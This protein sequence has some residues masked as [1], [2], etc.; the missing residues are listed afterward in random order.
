MREYKQ[1]E[2][3][4]V[5]IHTRRLEVLLIERASHAGY[6]QSVTG[7]REG[8]EPLLVAA[9]REV[10]EETGINADLSNFVDWKLSNR[11]EIFV[12]WRH[13]YAP[14]VTHNIEHVFSLCLD[15]QQAVTLAANEH[16]AWRWLPQEQAALAC[17]SWTNRDAI[18][19]LERPTGFLQN[20]TVV[21]SR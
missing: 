17:F 9:Q 8:A 1:P 2:S 18:L 19:M 21:A 10:A 6:W 20:S 5:V 15:Q 4:L 16:R 3:V 11:F 13:R 7:S 14:G 12:E